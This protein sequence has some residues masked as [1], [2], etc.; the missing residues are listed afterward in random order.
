LD[1]RKGVS[2]GRTAAAYQD[3][4]PLKEN[5]RKERDW[6]SSPVLIVFA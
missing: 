1:G 5:A 3:I 2:T 4:A 6:I